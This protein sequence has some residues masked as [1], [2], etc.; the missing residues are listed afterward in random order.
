MRIRCFQ[1]L[2]NSLE[3]LNITLNFD[4]KVKYALAEKGF[5]PVY[6]ARPLPPRNSE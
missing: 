2:K 4:E 6:G 1:G 5:D 3:A